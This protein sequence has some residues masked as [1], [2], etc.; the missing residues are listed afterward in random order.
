MWKPIPA[1]LLTIVSLSSF[2]S[3]ITKPEVF[4]FGASLADIQSE[5]TNQCDYLTVQNI[6]PFTAP[7]ARHSQQQINCMGF[8]YAGQKRLIE[9]VFQDDQLDLVWIL[10]PEAELPTLRDNF[11]QAF[12]MPTLSIAWG[13]VYLQHNMGIRE[14]PSEVLFA[15]QRQVNAMLNIMKTAQG[16]Q[17]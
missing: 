7:L 15:S 13:S 17:P 4:R 8:E 6:N 2:A 3:D 10:I 12:G 11:R 16:Q 9:L 1:M 14:K 5:L